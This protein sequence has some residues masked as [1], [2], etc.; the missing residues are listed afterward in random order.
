M[1]VRFVLNNI[2]VADFAAWLKRRIGRPVELPRSED[3]SATEFAA[4]LERWVELPVELPRGEDVSCYAL[5]A[6]HEVTE[7]GVVM[8]QYLVVIVGDEDGG[9]YLSDPGVTRF[10]IYSLGSNRVEVQAACDS[11][12]DEFFE[13]LLTEIVITWPE[14]SGISISKKRARAPLPTSDEDQRLRG[15]SEVE[16][17]MIA[18]MSNRGDP[19][20][21]IAIRLGRTEKCVSLA[22]AALWERGCI[23]NSNFRPRRRG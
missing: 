22:R 3:V 6:P 1:H 8:E 12:A 23:P 15:L 4:W 9:I 20:A 14:A 11:L 10:G 18:E 13:R 7:R 2:S 19:V 5:P 17:A 21:E 16:I